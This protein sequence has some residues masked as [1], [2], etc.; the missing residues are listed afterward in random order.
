MPS[1]GKRVVFM[2]SNYN[3]DVFTKI[4]PILRDFIYHYISYK[5]IH[6]RIN[7]L[8]GD[9]EFWAIT[10]SS[11]LKVASTSWCMVFGAESSNP[12]HWKRLFMGLDENPI[13][14]FKKCILENENITEQEFIS[15]WKEM[16]GF[17]NEYIVHRELDYNKPVPYFQKAYNIVILFDK[18]IREKIKPDSMG[19]ETL[20]KFADKFKTE[21]NKTVKL[22]AGH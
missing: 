15:Y 16:T 4:Y 18:W 6:S 1:N 17:R 13:V 14:E 11:H 22:I 9:Q 5:E 19:F 20:D 3:V 2:C 7:E 10:C 21:V 8:P 12:T